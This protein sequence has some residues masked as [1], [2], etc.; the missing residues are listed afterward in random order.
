MSH[1]NENIKSGIRKDSTE[2]TLVY[3]FPYWKFT[4]FEESDLSWAIPLGYVQL[5]YTMWKKYVNDKMTSSGLR[6]YLPHF[7][8]QLEVRVEEEPT[9]VMSFDPES[10]YR[11]KRKMEF[12]SE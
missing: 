11:T 12:I 9:V 1:L 3:H 10:D 5:S 8:N 7:E 4:E 2:N 6:S